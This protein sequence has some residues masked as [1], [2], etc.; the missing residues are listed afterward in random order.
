MKD[1]N[2]I[3]W[4]CGNRTANYFYNNP[5]YRC[6]DPYT[7][8]DLP[9]IN[10]L[11]KFWSEYVMQFFINRNDIQSDIVT[12][13]HDRRVVLYTKINAERI[14]EENSFQYYSIYED[15]MTKEY[16]RL[17]N[18]I[19]SIDELPDVRF[20]NI[21][22]ELVTK[23]G[24]PRFMYE[25]LIEFLNKQT[26][27]PLETI[28]QIAQED[29]S[30]FITREMY[31]CTWNM[32]KELQQYILEYF[33]FIQEKYQLDYNRDRH[34]D[35]FLTAIVPHYRNMWQQLE[36]KLTMSRLLYQTEAFFTTIFNK[37]L[38][39]GLDCQANVY[40]LF[41][42]NLEYLINLFIKSRN[43]FVNPECTFP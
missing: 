26:F 34:A 10:H 42:Y 43:H 16:D 25:D 27:V 4:V 8:K 36:G 11:N 40:R 30:V 1:I 23:M 35:F 14:L 33:D 6:F 28:Y 31:S 37:D 32:F 9:N 29:Y 24:Q 7:P 5:F 21:Y 17:N 19:A 41:S 20:R 38:R 39:Y 15:N 12:V 3:V 13:C 22:H 18:K 2:S